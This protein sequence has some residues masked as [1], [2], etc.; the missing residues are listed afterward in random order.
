MN[1]YASPEGGFTINDKL[2]AK[3]QTT[4]EGYVKGQLKQIK[5]ETSVDDRYT[6][7]DWEGFKE[8]VEASDLQD[9]AVILR[10]LS[11]YKD[12]E[13]RERQIRN[14]SEGFR[15]LATGILPELR[16]A[17]LTINYEVIGRSDEQIKEQFNAD[18]TQLS[19]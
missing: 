1:A 6:A 9:K 4:G 2:A 18:P 11:M 8:L 14:M 15:E 19:S 13:E 5:M 17:R 12:P 3:R 10:V 16:R 7:Q